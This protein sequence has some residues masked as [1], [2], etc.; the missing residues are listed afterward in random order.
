MAIRAR[1]KADLPV[2]EHEK[3]GRKKLN[4][5]AYRRCNII[6]RCVNKPMYTARYVGVL[7]HHGVSSKSNAES[8]L[9]TQSIKAHEAPF[10]ARI[11]KALASL[12]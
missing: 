11:Q 8:L 2:Q 5:A 4:R 6:E 9:R 1:H 7:A 3:G 12:P 10:E